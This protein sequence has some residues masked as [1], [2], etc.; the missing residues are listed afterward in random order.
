MAHIAAEALRLARQCLAVAVAR[1]QDENAQAL[2][3][4]SAC[5]DLQGLNG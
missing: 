1:V 4:E 2:W 3:V 5:H